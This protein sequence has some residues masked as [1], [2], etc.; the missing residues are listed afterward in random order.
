MDKNKIQDL[1]SSTIVDALEGPIY[2]HIA[3]CFD[4][5][6]YHLETHPN[7]LL[8]FSVADFLLFAQNNTKSSDATTILDVLQ[9]VSLDQFHDKFGEKLEED[10][11]IAYINKK[12][13]T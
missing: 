6:K 10:Y 4:T 11:V 8:H 7:L 13:L 12:I 1:L 9:R 5:Q 2:R 3:R